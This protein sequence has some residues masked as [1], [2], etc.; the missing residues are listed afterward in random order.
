MQAGL[1][2]AVLTAFVVESYHSLLPDETQVSINILERISSQ[3]DKN[4]PSPN[5]SSEAQSDPQYSFQPPSSAVTINSLWFLSLVFSL[6]AALFGILAKQW[7]REYLRWNHVLAPSREN[8][9]I[10]QMRL[11]AWEDWR[12]LTIVSIIPALLEIGVI[13]FLIGMI[14][15]LCT[16]NRTVALVSTIAIVI[17]LATASCATIL[18]AFSRR[19]PYRSSTSWAFVYLVEAVRRFVHSFSPWSEFDTPTNVKEWRQRDLQIIDRQSAEGTNNA[20]NNTVDVARDIFELTTLTKALVWMLCGSEGTH[21]VRDVSQCTRSLHTTRMQ[22]GHATAQSP[23]T[24]A[25]YYAAAFAVLRAHRLKLRLDVDTD[26]RRLAEA[27]DTPWK[28]LDSP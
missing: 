27:F 4:T 22:L 3:L 15:F 20:T 25:A 8:V 2:S 18:P 9:L 11:E 6:A 13:M 5:A 12:I 19:C 21:L 23:G 16:L 24:V 7:L 26:E 1:F 28:R 10:R 14:V 17:F